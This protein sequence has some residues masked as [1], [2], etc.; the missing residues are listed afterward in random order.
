MIVL[1][2]Q[3]AL[4]FKKTLYATICK[5]DISK[6]I[7][8]QKYWFQGPSAIVKLKGGGSMGFLGHVTTI[9]AELPPA[10]LDRLG[11]RGGGGGLCLGALAQKR[12]L[13]GYFCV[14]ASANWH[15]RIFMHEVWQTPNFVINE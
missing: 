3:I 13:V 1:F 9:W 8:E 5:V 10:V 6:G 15:S 7:F 12:L 11:T 2:V 14:E 4:K